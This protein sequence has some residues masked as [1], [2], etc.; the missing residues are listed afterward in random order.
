MVKLYRKP[1]Q[2]KRKKSI[3]KNRFF[4]LSILFL[5]FLSS[6]FYFLFLS[7]TFQVGKIIVLRQTQDNPEPVEWVAAGEKKVSKDELKSLIEKNLGNKILFFDT[8]SIFLVNLNGLRK[9]IL[10]D[11]PQIAGVEIKRKFPDTLDFIVTERAVTA[12]LCQGEKCFLLDN[13][14]VIFALQA[15]A[16]LPAVASAEAGAEAKGIPSETNLIKIIDEQ[17]REPFKLGEKAIEKEDLSK[18]LAVSSK[19]SDFKIPVKE[20]LIVS[21]EK[22]EVL[23][24]EDWKIYL[25]LRADIDWQMTKLRAVLEEKI[26]PENRK[27][28]EYIELR[29][30]NLA[31]YK[32]KD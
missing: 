6:V 16:F 5:I 1:H 20:F 30:G 3:L 8:K 15:L 17:N 18:I 12:D 4:W 26:P 11:F 32:F 23:T 19:L 31:P 21:G 14:G 10:N 13:E 27:D 24:S 7:Q 28:L 29:F 22:L 25:S 9:N 2:Y